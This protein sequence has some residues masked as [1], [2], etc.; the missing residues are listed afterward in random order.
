MGG[1][2]GRV[3]R[4][5]PRT[6]RVPVVQVTC[7][8]APSVN[9]SLVGV[10]LVT[11]CCF[12]PMSCLLLRGRYPHQAFSTARLPW[13]PLFLAAF[14]VREREDPGCVVE[15]GTFLGSESPCSSPQTPPRLSDHQ[16]CGETAPWFA[17][18]QPAQLR[19]SLAGFCR[20]RVPPV[21]GTFKLGIGP[22]CSD[23]GLL[24]QS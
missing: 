7:S 23:L 18:R 16:A 13:L 3:S 8:A 14:F 24:F 19:P 10:L 2:R 5:F 15:K 4:T 11:L 1:R 6:F 12:S 22:F 9:R 21:S 17:R 20:L